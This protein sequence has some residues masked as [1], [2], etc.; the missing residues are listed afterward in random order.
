[1][2]VK[3]I[4]SGMFG[5]PIVV[6]ILVL[7][8]KYVVDAILAIIAVVSIH[9]YMKCV[10]TKVNPVK[11]VGYVFA[12]LIAFIHVIPI[13]NLGQYVGFDLIMIVVLLFLIVKLSELKTNIIDISVTLFGVI[14][15][16]GFISYISILYGLDEIGK[17]YVWY[18]FAASWGSDV[19]AYCIG[20]RFGKHKFSKISPN[21]S[22]E[23]CIAGAIGGTICTLG[24]TVALNM[25]FGMDIN[26]LTIGLIGLILSII[27][28]LG[29]FSA[30]SIKRY[31]EVKDFSNLIPG[32]GGMIDRI[33]SVI[34]IAPFT[35]YLLKI[36]IM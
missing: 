10:D 23:G 12:A 14:Y 1:M 25:F 11:W 9:E 2:N 33:D 27:G 34:F 29:D 32:H 19:L 13:A 17:Y 22:L 26:Y 4:L 30:S 24:Y 20:K 6:A 3:R 5:L 18:I 8:N 36:F 35:Y 31:A 15:I 21:K 7:G 16:V 28:Q